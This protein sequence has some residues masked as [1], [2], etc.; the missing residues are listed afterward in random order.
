LNTNP[1]NQNEYI[2]NAAGLSKSYSDF[3]AVDAID[4]KIKSGE[5]FGFLGPNGA[6]KTTTMRMLYLASPMSSGQLEILGKDISNKKNH[7]DVKRNLGVVPQEDSL[8]QELSAREN[9]E[10]FCRFYGLTGQAL[11]RKADEMLDFV[12][13]KEKG[14]VIVSKLSGGMKRRLLV[15][16]GLLGSPQILILDEPT[17]GLDPQ[18]RQNLWEKIRQLKRNKVTVLLTTHYMDEAEQLC[19][20]L[21]IM[22]QGK[23]VARGSPRELI[24]QNLPPHVIEVDAINPTDK[25]RIVNDVENSVDHHVVLSDRILLYTHKT[26]VVMEC[27]AGQDLQVFVRRTTLEDVFLKITGRRL[28][29]LEMA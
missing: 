16:R 4:L 8:D 10:V 21:V 9:L 7:H 19:D 13:L 28:E 5:C 23:I 20:R 24:F 14:G 22:D 29:S 3:L 27:L 26:E 17:T 11:K 1:D 25:K 6:G 12:N 2:I 18:A 15:A